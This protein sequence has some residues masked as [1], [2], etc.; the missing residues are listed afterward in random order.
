M[1]INKLCRNCGKSFPRYLVIDGR[2]RNLRKRIYCFECS[3][4]G[5]RNRRILEKTNTEGKRCPKCETFKTKDSFYH[6]RNGKLS[7]YCIEC[8]G[9]ESK[10]R[11]LKF[12][13]LCVSYKGGKCKDCGY[14]R[15][16][17][18]M[19][20]HHL[21]EKRVGISELRFA[22]FDKNVTDELD[23]CDL[24]CSN[25]HRER[26]AKAYARNKPSFL[27]FLSGHPK[28]KYPR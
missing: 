13:Q 27:N 28:I 8:S 4:F 19:D 10:L 6:N 24:L 14:S 1:N 26:H 16:L 25:C 18:A 7:P 22:V 23:R 9:I 12:K 5:K 20:F 11:Q 15:C 21:D 17:A 2:R 3:P